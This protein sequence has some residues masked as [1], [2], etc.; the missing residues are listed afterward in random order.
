MPRP[1][2]SRV[3][4]APD[5]EHL[6]KGGGRPGR[7]NSLSVT[8][9]GII[10]MHTHFLGLTDLCLW[11]GVGRGRVPVAKGR[12]PV[13]P[14]RNRA[15]RGCCWRR[16]SEHDGDAGSAGHV[17]GS[18]G[19]E[20]TP[21]SI[22]DDRKE[23]V[24]QHG[25]RACGSGRMGGPKARREAGVSI[26]YRHA[27]MACVK[28]FKTGNDGC[29]LL[30]N[31]CTMFFTRMQMPGG[32]LCTTQK[33]SSSSRHCR[34]FVPAAPPVPLRCPGLFRVPTPGTARSV[35][36]KKGCQRAS[37]QGPAQT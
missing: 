6:G 14:A 21:A 33:S 18:M 8:S 19:R 26:T 28:T 13:E 35:A 36:R 9:C 4:G 20:A 12:Q 1:P 25:T 15:G 34:S 29:L 17:E 23:T 10:T 11:L 2:I 24:Q 5:E 30:L 3:D 7:V 37:K 16:Q 32:A 22:E 27:Q 31:V